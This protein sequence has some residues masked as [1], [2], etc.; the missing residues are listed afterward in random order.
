MITRRS[1]VSGPD[2]AALP[3]KARI[4]AT[5][6]RGPKV[7]MVAASLEI[8]G[9]QGVQA[10]TL[11]ERLRQDGCPVTFI[12]INPGFPRGLRGLRRVPF[13]R[14]LLNQALYLPSLRRLRQA[15]V[16]HVFS[17]SYWSFLL[18]VVPAIRAARAWG[19]RTILNYHSGEAA[20]HLAR[21]GPL[22]HPWLRRVDDI[23]VPSEFLRDVF[24]RHGYEAQVV[25][26]VVELA[27]F[28]HRERDPLLRRLLSVRNLEEHY[29]VE[30]TIDAFGLLRSRHR[31]ATLTIAGYGAQESRL[32]A[33]ASGL[34]DAVR[35]LG[36]VEPPEIPRLYDEH[37]VFLNSS[38]VDN[39][40]LSI[41]EAFASGLP[42]VS[43]ATGGISAMVRHGE[44]GLIVPA[45]DP[46]SMA[47]AVETLWERPETARAMAR[48][49]RQE[50]A[51]YTWPHVREKWLKVYAGQ[52]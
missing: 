3:A 23:V 40:P 28:R 24:A 37:D 15:D 8:L 18:S 7:A 14:T 32:R 1:A 47:R 36:R 2:V 50:A 51:R 41:L 33:M 38:V 42:V 44:T 9:G 10:S 52:A 43:T 48:R 30:N 25:P 12:P 22:V 45:A 4:D 31:D 17:A 27:R 46:A 39:Q 19:K 34:G 16:A 49:A 11:A 5:P 13:L 20:D 6:P 26:N 29:R 35:F 21:W